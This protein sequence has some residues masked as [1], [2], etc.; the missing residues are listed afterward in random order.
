MIKAEFIDNEKGSK[1]RIVY[2]DSYSPWYSLYSGLL[3]WK[4][5]NGVIYGLATPYWDGTLPT[6]KPFIIEEVKK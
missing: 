3:T 6:G 4:A 1:W 5:P 2:G